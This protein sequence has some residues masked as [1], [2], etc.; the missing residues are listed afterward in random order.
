MGSIAQWQAFINL[1]E[2][3][4]VN[5]TVL[6]P[7]TVISTGIPGVPPPP[8][9]PPVTTISGDD[10]VTSRELT[11]TA[12]DN[13]GNG[14]YSAEALGIPSTD[15]IVNVVWIG[16]DPAKTGYGHVPANWSVDSDGQLVV[17]G[18]VPGGEYGCIIWLA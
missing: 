18:G 7:V 10:E 11:L 15:N 9:P 8:P 12:L 16:S 14:Y 3:Q 4:Q 17:E 1:A 2:E 5:T 6:P 13:N